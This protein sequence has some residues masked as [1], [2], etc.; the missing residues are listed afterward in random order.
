MQLVI[1]REKVKFQLGLPLYQTLVYKTRSRHSRA[2]THMHRVRRKREPFS[3][4]TCF[5]REGALSSVSVELLFV[6]PIF[7]QF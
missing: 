1:G 2:D 7:V 4:T 6:E 3:L 5:R